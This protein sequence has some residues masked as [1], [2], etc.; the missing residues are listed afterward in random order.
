VTAQLNSTDLAGGVTGSVAVVN[1]APG[2]GSSAQRT[3]A[4][5]SLVPVLKSLSPAS[6]PHGG[7]CFTIT[8]SGSNFNTLSVVQ[9]NGASRATTFV[10]S[11]TL[12]AIIQMADTAAAG[13]A[14][15]TVSNKAP[16]GGVS[17]PLIFTI[18]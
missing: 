14:K 7:K 18:N 1:P 17:A 12:T 11:T 2:G 5:S 16:G 6:L 10:N 4:V 3:F 8:V 9:W 15:V 13:S